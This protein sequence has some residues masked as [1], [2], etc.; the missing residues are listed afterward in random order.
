MGLLREKGLYVT[1]ATHKKQLENRNIP[2]IKQKSI[3]GTKVSNV[4]FHSSLI[5]KK[6]NYIDGEL[7][8]FFPAIL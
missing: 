7:F 3:C 1:T 4:F 2:S 5:P 8:S 6:T